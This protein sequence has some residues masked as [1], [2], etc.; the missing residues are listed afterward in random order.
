MRLNRK[1]ALNIIRIDAAQH[2]MATRPGLQAYLEANISRD[3]FEE[4]VKLGQA[5]YDQ[6][7][8]ALLTSRPVI[9]TGHAAKSHPDR[10]RL[11]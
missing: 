6:T 1:V 8:A 11:V 3:A 7:Q 10:A 5:I 2:G 4:A 9:T